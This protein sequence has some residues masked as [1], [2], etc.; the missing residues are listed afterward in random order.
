MHIHDRNSVSKP[1]ESYR[2]H[3]PCNVLYPEANHF[4]VEG[5]I[6]HSPKKST[7]CF[8][9]GLRESLDQVASALRGSS[10]ENESRGCVFFMNY[11]HFD[12]F[13][14]LGAQTANEYN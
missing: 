3:N 12:I 8:P 13:V 2:W 1:G 9:A 7:I 11:R 5:I 10:R 14:D 6:G 4:I